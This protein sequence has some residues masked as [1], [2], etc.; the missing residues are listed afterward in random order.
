MDLKGKVAVVT[1]GNGGLGQRICHALAKEG[2]HVAVV[3]AQSKGDAEGVARDLAKHQVNAA[4]FGCDVTKREQVQKLVDDVVKRFGSL[5]LLI[6]DAAYN[7]AIAFTDLDGMTYGG[8]A[9]DEE[10]GPRADREHLVGGGVGADRLVDRLCRLEGR[11]DSS[12]QV[13]GRGDGAGG[14][15]ELRGA[16]PARRHPR[17]GEPVSGFGREG[18]GGGAIGRRGGQGRLRRPGRDDVPDQHDDR[19]D[20]RDRRGTHVSL[21]TSS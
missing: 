14:A 2:C 3:Y 16:R 21:I 8:G 11:L 17:D 19:P 18:Q 12:H 13:H 9:G 1:G 7:K 5:D 6:N 20:D 15:G 10:A 4:A